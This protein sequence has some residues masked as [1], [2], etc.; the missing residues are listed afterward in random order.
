[1]PNL[2]AVDQT[3]Q[4]YTWRSAGKTGPLRSAFQGHLR[5]LEL[6]RINRVTAASY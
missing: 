4:T 6:T 5:S 1:M 3:V 2:I